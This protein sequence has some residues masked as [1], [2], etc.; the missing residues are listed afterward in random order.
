MGASSG[1][2]TRPLDAGGDE[3]PFS[4][5]LRLPNTMAEEMP[6]LIGKTFAHYCVLERIG[7]GGMGVVYRARDE[8]LERDVALKVLPAGAIA[9]EDARKR[10]RREA[11]ALSRL[12]HPNVA[13]V[14]DFDTRDG[15]DFLV[16]EHIPGE[17]LDAIIRRGPL[18]APE[19]IRLGAQIAQGL[20]A[21]HEQGILHGDLKPGNLRVTPSGLVKVLDFGLARWLRAPGTA[22]TTATGSVTR[23]IE[24]TLPYMAPEQIRGS[25]IDVRAD[26]YAL[27]VVLYEMATG[28]PP[29]QGSDA[30]RLLHAILDSEPVLPRSIL[31]TI[32][33]ELEAVCLKAMARDREQRYPNAREIIEALGVSSAGWAEPLRVT[34]PPSPPLPFDAAGSLPAP[35]SSF[36]GREAEIASAADL[37]SRTRLLTLT[38]PGGTGKTRTGLEIAS[39]SR[40]CFRDG[41]AFIP[42]AA[43]REPPL[44]S[45]AFAQALGIHEVGG[46]PITETMKAHL[47]SKELLLLIDNFEQVI[48]A[49]PLVSELLEACPG[50][51]LFQ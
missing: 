33:A 23:N 14:H 42:L 46:Q 36:I 49:A 7:A 38:G 29:F 1:H 18:P 28:K 40:G 10:F 43:I 9:G 35:V 50:K 4:K 37:L 24:G 19:V 30:I 34:P 20:A 45:C 27:G 44:V 12:S 16:M 41:A 8:H 5:R 6:E 39:R 22:A 31:S 26:L 17:T 47:R 13:T 2:D 48:S 21:A 11:L 3:A 25:D 32:P 15:I 51:G